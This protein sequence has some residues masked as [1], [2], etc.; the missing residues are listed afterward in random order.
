MRG[1]RALGRGKG[2]HRLERA[3]GEDPE[4]VLAG[5]VRQPPQRGHEIAVERKRLQAPAHETDGRRRRFR[6]PIEELAAGPS[7]IVRTA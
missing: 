4:L 6:R 7:H 1:K 2:R 5:R 3:V